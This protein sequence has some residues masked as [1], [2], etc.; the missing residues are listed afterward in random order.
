LKTFHVGHYIWSYWSRRCIES[1]LWLLL[2][3]PAP[4]QKCRN[5]KRMALGLQLCKLCSYSSSTIFLKI[6]HLFQKHINP[7]HYSSGFTMEISRLRAMRRVNTY[8][9]K[10]PRNRKQIQNYFRTFTSDLRGSDKWKKRGL[11]ISWDC[12][13]KAAEI[14]SCTSIVHY[15][16]VR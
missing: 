14:V 7:K 6:P 8:S 10:S 3:A 5:R 15:T 16:V 12:P 13:F 2:V 11:K 4:Q 1:R 9:R